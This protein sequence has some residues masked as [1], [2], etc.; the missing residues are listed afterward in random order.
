LRTDVAVTLSEISL[1]DIELKSTLL[2]VRHS[3]CRQFE[4]SGHGDYI[5]SF[6]AEFIAHTLTS[7][8]PSTGTR[9]EAK[10]RENVLRPPAMYTSPSDNIQQNLF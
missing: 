2:V 3:I 9:K 7:R 10:W 1:T 8:S 5:N 4:G 6:N